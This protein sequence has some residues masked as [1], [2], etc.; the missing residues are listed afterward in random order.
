MKT[1]TKGIFMTGILKNKT[2]D[3]LGWYPFPLSEEAKTLIARRI[4]DIDYVKII[5]KKRKI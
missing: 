2:K 3:S 1:K 5:I 4:E